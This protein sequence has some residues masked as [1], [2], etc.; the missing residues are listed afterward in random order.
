MLEMKCDSVRFATKREKAFE[1]KL[2]DM[3]WKQ[4]AVIFQRRVNK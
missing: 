1:R 4:E 2:K 3:D